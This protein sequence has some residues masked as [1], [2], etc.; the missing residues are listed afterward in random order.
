[1]DVCEP[2]RDDQIVGRLGRSAHDYSTSALLPCT[3]CRQV[4]HTVHSKTVNAAVHSTLPY[5][6]FIHGKLPL[7]LQYLHVL[8]ME[9]AQSVITNES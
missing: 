5:L 9:S 6:Q 8:L 3:A 4:L 2:L 7:V 1:L